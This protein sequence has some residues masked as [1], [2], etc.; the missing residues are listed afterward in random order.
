MDKHKQ[1]VMMRRLAEKH[2][3]FRRNS[4]ASMI[5]SI[6]A[7]IE[8]SFHK[9]FDAMERERTK[10]MVTIGYL[11]NLTGFKEEEIVSALN[12]LLEATEIE[13]NIDTS[14]PN[15]V[16]YHLVHQK[17]L[18]PAKPEASE[19]ESSSP[20]QAAVKKKPKKAT[21]RKRERIEYPEEFEMTMKEYPK[22]KGGMSKKAGY[23]AWSARIAEG[24]SVENLLQ[25]TKNYFIASKESH[26]TSFIMMPSTFFGPNERYAD[27]LNLD[28]EEVEVPATELVERVESG[29]SEDERKAVAL[30]KLQQLDD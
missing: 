7:D 25:A 18:V 1:I 28:T 4:I 27:Y 2:V 10:S 5:Y 3:P 11:F 19:Q 24:E 29:L 20:T 13:F 21:A 14:N 17:E 15:L 30:K 23:K 6:L 9:C 12:T 22:R 26:N 16:H 8:D